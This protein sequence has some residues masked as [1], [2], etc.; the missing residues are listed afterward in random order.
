MGIDSKIVNIASLAA[1]IGLTNL[2]AYSASKG[3]VVS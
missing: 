1:H 2:C 3:G